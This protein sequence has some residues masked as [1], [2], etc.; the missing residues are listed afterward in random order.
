VHLDRPLGLI[1]LGR[2]QHEWEDILGAPVDLVPDDG[3]KPDI[4]A[5]VERDA[6]AL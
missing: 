2:L 1:G 3:L 4:R 5:A 6:V